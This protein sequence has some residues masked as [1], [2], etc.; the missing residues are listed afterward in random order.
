MGIELKKG[1]LP[2]CKACAIAKAK[3]K[4]VTKVTMDNK[5]TIFNGRVSHDIV[6][7]KLTNDITRVEIN[8]SN[9]TLQ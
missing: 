1:S 6:A 3:Q 4:N 9:C 8:R 5:A 7:L 2:D